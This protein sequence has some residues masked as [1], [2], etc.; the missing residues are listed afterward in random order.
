MNFIKR[1]MKFLRAYV[2]WVEAGKP[3]RSDEYIFELYEICKACPT[4]KFIQKREGVGEC[5]ECDCH[6]LRASSTETIINKLAFPTEGCP[7]GH[8]QADV[9][10]EES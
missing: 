2:K 8:W 5:G 3:L 9:D 7:D 10:E 1:G 4:N 6:I